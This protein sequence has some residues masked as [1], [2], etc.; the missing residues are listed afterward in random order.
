LALIDYAERV[1]DS[2]VN[3]LLK[4]GIDYMLRHN[5]YLRLSS[6]MPICQ[7]ITDIMMPQSY[8]LSLTD[9]VY[10]IGK[11]GLKEESGAARVLRLLQERQ[12]AP[13]EWKI[14]YQ[15]RYKGYIPFESRRKASEWVSSL[16][17]IWLGQHKSDKSDSK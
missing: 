3:A 4:Q 2:K 8:A 11:V 13:D 15:Y 10:I 16:F 14:D 1:N 5:M 9:L 12:I 17:P 7:H 6:G